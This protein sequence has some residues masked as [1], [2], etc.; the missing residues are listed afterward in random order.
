MNQGWYRLS[1]QCLKILVPEIFLIRYVSLPAYA[2]VLSQSV[3]ENEYVVPAEDQIFFISQ[4]FKP[5]KM[6]WF[7]RPSDTSSSK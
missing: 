1:Q 4:P 3:G 2:G 6:I 7:L 5:A